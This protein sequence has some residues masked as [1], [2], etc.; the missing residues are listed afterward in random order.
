MRYKLIIYPQYK[1]TLLSIL[2]LRCKLYLVPSFIWVV[3]KSVAQWAYVH[4]GFYKSANVIVFEYFTT[5]V[6]CSC[7]Q[8]IY[9]T[10]IHLKIFR[11]IFVCIFTYSIS[12]CCLFLVHYEYNSYFNKSILEISSM[13]NQL[14]SVNINWV[15]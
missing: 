13:L 4:N 11:Y 12:L 10:L 15:T 2:L 1:P 6:T 7:S 5:R 3:I 8:K 9:I 14:L